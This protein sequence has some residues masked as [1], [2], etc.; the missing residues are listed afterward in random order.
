MGDDAA[1]EEGVLVAAAG[2][3]EELVRQHDV[4]RM[5]YFSCRLPTAVTAMIQR[6]FRLRSAQRFAR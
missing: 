3:V 4:A 6:T 2:A 5:V 1:A